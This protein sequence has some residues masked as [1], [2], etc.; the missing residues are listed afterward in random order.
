M[1]EQNHIPLPTD[2]EFTRYL[3]VLNVS[4][5]VLQLSTSIE[6][7]VEERMQKHLSS[8]YDKLCKASHPKL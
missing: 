8:A 5:S 6:K 7:E 1:N 3:S 2:L 4:Y